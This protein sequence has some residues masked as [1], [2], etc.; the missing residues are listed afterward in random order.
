[1]ATASVWTQVT[2]IVELKR[3]RKDEPNW[4]VTIQAGDALP[5]TAWQALEGRYKSSTKINLPL[6]VNT[7]LI[8]REVQLNQFDLFTRTSSLRWRRDEMRRDPQ[9]S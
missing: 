5:E 6:E 3:R 2:M 7:M 4:L 8:W 9:S 1:M